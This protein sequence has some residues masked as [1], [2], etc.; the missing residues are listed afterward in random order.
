[1]Y[2][3]RKKKHNFIIKKYVIG[4]LVTPYFLIYKFNDEE[5]FL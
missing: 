3:W 2:Y 1:M 5:G 4:I